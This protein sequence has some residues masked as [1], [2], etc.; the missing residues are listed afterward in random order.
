VRPRHVPRSV[1]SLLVAASTVGCADVPP[2]APAALPAG[3][4]PRLPVVVADAAAPG[5]GPAA[6][7][8]SVVAAS[9][10]GAAGI[11]LPPPVPL[12]AFSVQFNGYAINNAG[13]VAGLGVLD[14]LEAHLFLWS[15]EHGLEDLG[16]LGRMSTEGEFGI[17]D[18]GHIVGESDDHAFLWTRERGMEDLGTLPG[19][20]FSV[21]TDINNAGQVVGR[22][23]QPGIGFHWFLWTRER[24]MQDLRAVVGEDAIATAINDA[25]AI[26]GG[27]HGH[28]FLWTPEQ[29]MRD[30][31]V[32]PGGSFSIATAVNNA[33]QV[34]GQSDT[35]GGTQRAFLWTPERGMEDLGA[36]MSGG[37]STAYGMNDD[38][39]VVG[40]SDMRCCNPDLGEDGIVQ[41][42]PFV[43]H[44]GT[45]MV[46]LPPP[47]A[48]SGTAFAVN[49]SGQMTGEVTGGGVTG[50]VLWTVRVTNVGA[51]A[52]DHVAAA[53]LPP[54]VMPGLSGVWLR[55]RLND[56]GDAGRW[57]W[58]IDWG[59]GIVTTPTEIAYT[60]EFAFLRS[61]QYR[62]PGPHT[63]RA[64]ATDPDGVTSAP[65]VTVVP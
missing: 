34:A 20:S 59:D 10:A 58:E 62:G 23:F 52:V 8:P 5:G 31:G 2:T 40:A 28:A 1:L 47:R 21:A 50:G 38:G 29:G 19:G 33:G 27:A 30:L 55:V 42:A 64:T 60:G 37:P 6:G 53:V 3:V 4:D 14:G 32:L 48:N 13:Q 41:N 43:W 24:G 51:P 39:L 36:L 49:N 35:E 15:P 11:I 18:A 22:S 65:A 12:S 63:I 44:R 61:A 7:R 56:P 57:N 16:T 26:V 9:R 54:G 45:G 46:R 17:N 25:G